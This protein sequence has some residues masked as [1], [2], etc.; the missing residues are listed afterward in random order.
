LSNGGK[1]Q[2]IL[3]F[4]AAT[5]TPEEL[6]LRGD[7]FK[8]QQN[9]A[10]CRDVCCGVIDEKFKCSKHQYLLSVAPGLDPFLIAV[11]AVNLDQKE[12]EDESGRAA[13]IANYQAMAGPPLAGQMCM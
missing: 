9:A 6:H 13:R 8:N 1:Y 10:F 3:K 5:G 7:S 12:N 4:T 2:T 11:L